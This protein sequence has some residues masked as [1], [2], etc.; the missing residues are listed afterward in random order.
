VQMMGGTIWAESTGLNG[1]GSTFYFTI[2]NNPVAIPPPPYLVRSQP[3]LMNKNVLLVCNYPADQEIL[4]RQ[5][6]YWGMHV[7]AVTLDESALNSLSVGAPFDLVILSI[8]SNEKNYSSL[9]RRIS[10]LPAVERKPLVICASGDGLQGVNLGEGSSISVMRLPVKPSQL[11]NILIRYINFPLREKSLSLIEPEVQKARPLQI[12]LAED[13]PTARLAFAQIL[14]RMGYQ[15]KMAM[16]GLEVLQALEGQ[17]FDIIFM[18]LYMPEMDGRETTHAIRQ[19]IKSDNQPYIVILTADARQE[20]QQELLAAGANLCLTK[21]VRRKMLSEVLS[22]VSDHHLPVK[23]VPLEVEAPPSPDKTER[24]IIDEVILADFMEAM[25]EDANEAL[26]Q[27]LDTF[28]SNAPEL[29]TG[30]VKAVNEQDWPKLKWYAHSLKGNSELL[31]ATHLAKIC[32]ELDTDLG[33]GISTDAGSRVNRIEQE[34]LQVIEVL[35]HKRA[36]L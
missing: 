2:Q 10:L 20:I 18:D 5:L 29:L 28:F 1:K 23:D 3:V 15:P 26:A 30:M 22:Q 32:K 34:F 9:V 4:S 31:G 33:K 16:S 36:E 24:K 17:R 14:D 35:K 8:R 13:D 25:G 19:Q 12:L 11:Y 6:A 27:L 7:K 21:P